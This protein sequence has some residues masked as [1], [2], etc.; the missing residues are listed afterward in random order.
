[1]VILEVEQ[2]ARPP[3][4]EIINSAG[5]FRAKYDFSAYREGQKPLLARMRPLLNQS[6]FSLSCR[7]SSPEKTFD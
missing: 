7:F 2:A 3:P 5:Q 4:A 1:V 6:G